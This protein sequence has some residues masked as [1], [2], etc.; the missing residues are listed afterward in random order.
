[1]AEAQA[2][3]EREKRVKYADKVGQACEGPWKLGEV[4]ASSLPQA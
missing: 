1:M 4:P 3:N 2:E